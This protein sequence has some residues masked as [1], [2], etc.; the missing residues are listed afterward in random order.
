MGWGFKGLRDTLTR[1][2]RSIHRRPGEER[3]LED[4]VITFWKLALVSTL[5]LL[6]I[7]TFAYYSSFRI[8]EWKEIKPI[9]RVELKD[10]KVLYGDYGSCPSGEIS[11][12]CPAH[13][14][15]MLLWESPFNKADPEHVE[16]VRALRRKAGLWVGAKIE[17]PSHLEERQFVIGLVQGAYEV[18]INGRRVLSGLQTGDT[19]P[20]SVTL[21]ED[22]SW[23]AIHILQINDAAYPDIFNRSLGGEGIFS[24]TGLYALTTFLAF[25]VQA[26]P[27]A[28]TLAQGVIG[29]LFLF[30]WWSAKRKQEYFYLSLFLFTQMLIQV[31][32]YD[33]VFRGWSRDFGYQVDLSL[34]ILEGLFALTLGLSFA[35]VRASV[36]QI[37]VPVGVLIALSPLFVTSGHPSRMLA[38]SQWVALKWVVPAYAIGALICLSQALI[39]VFE[40]SNEKDIVIIRARRLLFFAIG[41]SFMLVLYFINAQNVMS[42]YQYV[43]WYRFGHLGLVLFLS[44][45]V[46][47]EYREQENFVQ[48]AKLSKFVTQLKPDE[49]RLVN[50]TLLRVDL[51]G[52]KVM[53]AEAA[54]KGIGFGYGTVT[55][56][57]L[58]SM[59][60]VIFKNGGEVLSERGDEFIA[61]FDDLTFSNPVGT[62]ENVLNEMVD[63][64]FQVEHTLS[65]KEGE[66]QFRATVVTGKLWVRWKG[67]IP[68]YDGDVMA[69]SAR[70]LDLE[71]KLGLPK[72]SVLVIEKA[73]SQVV[74]FLES[75]YEKSEQTDKEGGKRS[76]LWLELGKL[77]S[78]TKLV[79]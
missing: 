5:A 25:S 76:L 24:Q 1:F 42:S 7:G 46:I 34:R 67:R 51:K 39:L 68:G 30:F 28:F 29:L 72:Q 35:R 54:S 44:S 3:S 18:F 71:K 65:L 19:V 75:D 37:V 43:F 20:Q 48:K 77:I 31:R 73:Q 2:A 33:A 74:P 41:L 36:F 9:L 16:K 6:G 12:N 11:R 26:K 14:E 66:M 8:K 64:Q 10:W 40:N 52:S 60:E 17:V 50:G 56:T 15:N 59:C 53:E 27:I 49:S 4:R 61:F 70:L 57:W 62:I 32:L 47:S 45:I 63:K 55:G 23:L 78:K 79:A 38:L 13:P 58:S 21:G 22:S 69:E